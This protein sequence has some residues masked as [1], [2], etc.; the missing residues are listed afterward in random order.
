MKSSVLDS[1]ATEEARRARRIDGE[2]TYW[3]DNICMCIYLI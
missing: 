2:V 3:N 1:D